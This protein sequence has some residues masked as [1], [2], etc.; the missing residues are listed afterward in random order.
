[1]SEDQIVEVIYQVMKL[2]LDI[3]RY[4]RKPTCLRNPHKTNEIKRKLRNAKARLT[5][6]KKKLMGISIDEIN[7][8]K[9]VA[10]KRLVQEN[11]R[12]YQ[13]RDGFSFSN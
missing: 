10:L 12:R 5:R 3:E 7:Q 9:E 2:V 6:T 11:P 13:L 1:M 4:E 8:Y